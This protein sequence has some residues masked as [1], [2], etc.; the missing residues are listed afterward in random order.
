LSLAIGYPFFDKGIGK[1]M[2]AIN[3]FFFK[4]TDKIEGG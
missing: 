2:S 3:L 4:L 1:K